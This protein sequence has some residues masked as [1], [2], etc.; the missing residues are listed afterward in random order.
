MLTHS[1]HHLAIFSAAH[2]SNNLPQLASDNL[3]DAHWINHQRD[4]KELSRLL[5]IPFTQDTPE[6][7]ASKSELQHTFHLPL[8]SLVFGSKFVFSK[9]QPAP[10]PMCDSKNISSNISQNIIPSV[11]DSDASGRK[12]LTC[13]PRH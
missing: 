11:E 12:D 3:H 13:L 2:P 5:L 6:S 8:Q 1:F 9:L 10:G 4:L 7:S